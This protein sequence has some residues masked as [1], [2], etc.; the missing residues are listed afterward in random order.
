MLYSLFLLRIQDRS[1][2][3]KGTE[4][5]HTAQKK[6]LLGVGTP[7]ILSGWGNNWGGK[8]HILDWG[9]TAHTLFMG[10][11]IVQTLKL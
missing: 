5:H 8:R 1:D 2:G 4:L 11:M 6:R 9:D 7:R 3:G 10:G